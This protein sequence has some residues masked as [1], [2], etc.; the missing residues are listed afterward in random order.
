MISSAVVSALQ[1]MPR[2]SVKLPDKA[3]TTILI[4][5]VLATERNFPH[6]VEIAPTR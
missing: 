1:A 4:R 6:I 2:G 3:L 5:K